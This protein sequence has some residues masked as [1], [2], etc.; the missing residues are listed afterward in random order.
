VS[1]LK[2][3][4]MFPCPVCMSPRE[5]KTTKKDKPYIVCD[6]C[7]VQVFVRGPAGIDEFERLL[8]RGSRNGTLG[9]LEEMEKRYRLN[10]PECGDGF[11]IERSLIK[12]SGFDGSLKGFRCPK[13][14]GIVPWEEKR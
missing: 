7:G 14:G 13:C 6:P 1:I 4:R 12:T 5:V 8:E 3:K 11:W 10:C 2:E 9:R